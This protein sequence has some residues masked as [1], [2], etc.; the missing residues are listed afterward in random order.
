MISFR[1][2]TRLCLTLLLL[3]ST[4]TAS[5][6]PSIDARFK[7]L[8]LDD[9]N[10]EEQQQF[11]RVAEGELCP[12]K[13]S[14]ESLARC[15]EAPKGTCSNARLAGHT[16]L[17]NILRGRSDAQL[18]RAIAQQL[19]AAANRHTF[20]LEGLPHQGAKK[21]TVTMVIFADFECPYCKRMAQITDDLLRAYP[22][23]LRVYFMHFPLASHSN[24]TDAAI[25]AYAAHKQGKFWPYHDK[26]FNEQ[27]ALQRAID[28]EPQ[29]QAWAKELGLDIKQFER[30]I[31][32]AESYAAVR[33]QQESGRNANVR[34]TPAIFLNG[35]AFSDLGSERALR[36]HIQ[37]LIEENQ[38]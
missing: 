6:E 38:P 1:T 7:A 2:T 28:A 36:A 27:R 34:G 17:Q 20:A 16:L 10:D 15:L 30:D 26:L 19:K 9:L 3:W 5:A 35:V 4:A 14:T 22:K 23:D 25:A 33:A 8:A 11:Q 18:S 29:L 13:G 32:D 31:E 12:C 21:P 37:S 24:A